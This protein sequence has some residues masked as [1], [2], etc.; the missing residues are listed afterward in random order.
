MKETE[1]KENK[2]ALEHLAEARRHHKKEIEI[3]TEMKYMFK[4]LRMGPVL[5]RSVGKREADIHVTDYN[6][7]VETKATGK[8]NPDGR[9]SGNETQKA[10]L[11][12]YVEGLRENLRGELDLEGIADK[13]WVGILT[14]GQSGWIWKWK[15]RGLEE[16]GNLRWNPGHTD[17]DVLGNIRKA[18]GN[19]PAGKRWVDPDE[20]YEIF[21]GD[22]HGFQ[23]LYRRRLTEDPNQEIKTKFALWLDR[24]RGSGM[25][26][27]HE[28]YQ[29]D[30]FVKHCFL[31]AV[32]KAVIA[33]LTPETNDDDPEA[34]L[35]EGFT[36]WL[37]ESDEGVEKSTDLFRKAKEYNW[38]F[39]FA[40]VLKNLYEQCI[41]K[42]DRKIYG[43]Y[44][45][46]DWIAEQ[47]AEEILDNE[48]I[49]S[50]AK[51]ALRSLDGDG[52]ALNGIGVLDPA[53]GSGTFLYHSA[54]R[55]SG[56]LAL[57]TIPPG[58]RAMAVARL[59]HG[60][61]IHPV[62]VEMAKATLLRAL[63]PPSRKWTE[64]LCAA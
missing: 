55:I 56:A 19:A 41:D 7:V 44:Y 18:L 28:L 63:P 31:V 53:C 20:I 8:A 26:P 38:R 33:A 49:E 10:Q 5:A 25:A 57:R 15:K 3:Q 11:C 16:L 23:C 40:D 14:D 45:T 30:L 42:K 34:V 27:E 54:R 39:R 22:E 58:R 24:L 37:V 46:P 62:A 64:L 1:E 59:V 21:R 35:G 48:W 50:A 13:P 12:S 9:G 52:E 47:M 51:A 4:S 61:D 32:A 2:Q 43:E 60:I 29:H 36:S 17:V 6:C